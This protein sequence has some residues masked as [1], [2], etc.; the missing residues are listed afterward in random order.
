MVRC[1]EFY[2]KWQKSGN[3]CELNPKAAALIDRYL[4]ELIKIETLEP[5]G[6]K[7]LS[8]SERAARPL[9]Q[10]KD[11]QVH[12]EAVKQVVALA[13]TKKAEGKEPIITGPE[14]QEIIDK[15]KPDSVP[16]V[17]ADTEEVT[18]ASGED[19]LKRE[20]CSAIVGV[21]AEYLVSNDL[22]KQEPVVSEEQ[23]KALKFIV[24]EL[25]RQE[26]V[27]VLDVVKHEGL[28]AQ[29]LK[30]LLK[31]LGIESKEMKIPAP[32]GRYF[33]RAMLPAMESLL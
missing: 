3:F 9:Y 27:S 28:T 5:M 15:L 4:D 31:P 12:D 13:A 29:E 20:L 30:A 18:A 25:K 26:R 6:S 17:T 23:A 32:R 14:V 16:A 33:T 2:E 19:E 8:I 7:D 21:I 10:E 22:L 11:L 24:A 1:D